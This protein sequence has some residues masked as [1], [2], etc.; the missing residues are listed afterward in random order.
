MVVSETKLP[1]MYQ[2]MRMRF[3]EFNKRG[4]GYQDDHIIVNSFLFADDGL[5]LLNSIEEAAEN[6]QIITQIAEISDWKLT[7]NRSNIMIFNLRNNR[8]T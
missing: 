6:L 5:L 4:I 7:K 2:R 1:I 3:E 8:N